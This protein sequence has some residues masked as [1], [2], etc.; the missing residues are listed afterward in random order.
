MALEF[1]F[2]LVLLLVYGTSYLFK[3]LENYDIPILLVEIIAGI[4]FGSVF[5]VVN[6][7][8][9]GW[10]F[11]TTLAAFGLLVIMFE[12]GLELDPEP[13]LERPKI[14]SL[15]AVMTFLLPFLA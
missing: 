12:A 2:V 14:V 8:I 1:H 15:M 5:G 3:F 13:V 10:E 4:I 7:N 6:E 11:F 9:A